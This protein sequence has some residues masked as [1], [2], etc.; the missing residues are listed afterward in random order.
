MVYMVGGFG[1]AGKSFGVSWAEDYSRRSKS[2]E[3]GVATLL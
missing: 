2:G 3:M 1:C